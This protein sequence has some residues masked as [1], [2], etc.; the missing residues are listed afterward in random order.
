MN[1]ENTIYRC[2]KCGFDLKEDKKYNAFG[3]SVCQYLIVGD[4]HEELVEKLNADWEK[5]NY[6]KR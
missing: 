1:F 2:P 3:C 4:T 6:L 5:V